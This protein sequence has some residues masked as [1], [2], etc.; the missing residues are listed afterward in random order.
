MVMLQCVHNIP[1][2]LRSTVPNLRILLFQKVVVQPHLNATIPLDFCNIFGMSVHSILC[3]DKLFYILIGGFFLGIT[4]AG[5]Q[6][7]RDLYFNLIVSTV[8]F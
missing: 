8:P 6:I 7:N 5:I 3:L 4:F 1:P 2:L